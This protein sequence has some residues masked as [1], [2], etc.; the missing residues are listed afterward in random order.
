MKAILPPPEQVRNVLVWHTGALGDLLLAGPALQ[1]LSRYYSGSGLFGVGKRECWELLQGTLPVAAVWDAAEGLWAWL[2]ADAGPVPPRLA[3]RLASISLA[4]V[5]RPRLSA[6]VLTR[7]SQAGVEAAC[8]IPSFPENGQE[9]V[10]LLQARHLAD[11]GLSYEPE[12]FFLNLEADGADELPVALPPDQPLLAVAPGSGNARK[13]WP[14]SH[15][16]EVT[17]TLA[18]EFGLHVVWLAGPAER[19]WLSYLRGIAASQGHTLAADLPLRQVARLLAR[20]HLYIGGDSGI[21]H[22]AA[23]ARARR[24]IALYGPTNPR[25]WGPFG[26]G[27]TVVAAPGDCPPCA[28]GRDIACPESRC[29]S[30]ISSDMVFKV[31]ARLLGEG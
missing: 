5:F 3:E 18:W 15:Y 14:L 25:V 29:L 24:V 2:F 23:A 20:T 9:P 6:P 16:F 26:H 30:E 10:R 31:A 11:M 12:P 27:V 13:N 17:R 28:A 22:L 8:W 4:L 7:F 21:T 19:P 1:A